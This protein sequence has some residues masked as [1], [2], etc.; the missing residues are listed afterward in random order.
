MSADSGSGRQRRLRRIGPTGGAS[1]IGLHCWSFTRFDGEASCCG[2]ADGTS[3]DGI[4]TP[5]TIIPRACSRFARGDVAIERR[6]RYA[7][8][9]RDFGSPRCRDDKQRLGGLAI[10]TRPATQPVRSILLIGAAAAPGAGLAALPGSSL[11]VEKAASEPQPASDRNS[12]TSTAF[13]EPIRPIE[14][15]N[16]HD[17]R[18]SAAYRAGRIPEHG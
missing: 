14:G 12:N 9:V 5:L 18:S 10:V 13:F 2:R 4:A 16:R 15:K 8:A 11:D 17:Q 6:R 1:P 3:I 7:E